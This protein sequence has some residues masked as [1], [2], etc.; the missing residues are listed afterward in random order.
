MLFDISIFEV[1]NV[2]LNH[3]LLI[4]IGSVSFGLLQVR[5]Y[6]IHECVEVGSSDIDSDSIIKLVRLQIRCFL[7]RRKLGA[8]A[9]VVLLAICALE[10]SRVEWRDLVLLAEIVDEV[11]I[12]LGAVAGIV[13]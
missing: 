11:S 8:N 9:Q 12:L 5:Y 7:G 3:L 4:L 1:L 6:F 10:E 13:G 2:V